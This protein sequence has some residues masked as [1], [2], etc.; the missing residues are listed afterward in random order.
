[1]EMFEPNPHRRTISVYRS[2]SWGTIDVE[3]KL[4]PHDFSI[5]SFSDASFSTYGHDPVSIKACVMERIREFWYEP[6]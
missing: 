4:S 6:L 3:V 2:P 1:M 5:T